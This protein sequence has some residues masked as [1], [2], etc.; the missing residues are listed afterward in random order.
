MCLC[1][2]IFSFQKGATR[3][4]SEKQRVSKIGQRCTASIVL[5]CPPVAQRLSA[6]EQHFIITTFRL[7]IFYHRGLRDADRLHVCTLGSDFY[8]HF[9]GV[10]KICPAF[11]AVIVGCGG[12]FIH[13]CIMDLFAPVSHSQLMDDSCGIHS[14]HHLQKLHFIPFSPARPLNMALIK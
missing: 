6:D 14:L 7:L 12:F 10:L 13:C 2:H 3:N 4:A 11:A 5:L 8:R 1:T 9:H